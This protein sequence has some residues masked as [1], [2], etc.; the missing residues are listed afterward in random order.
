VHERSLAGL[1]LR[2]AR[3]RRIARFVSRIT[4]P[5]FNRSKLQIPTVR[6]RSGLQVR[7]GT[8]TS[9]SCTHER[10]ACVNVW[11]ALTS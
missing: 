7:P 2:G 8:I 11:S 4:N 9:T 10:E 5:E 3:S 6:E 1:Q